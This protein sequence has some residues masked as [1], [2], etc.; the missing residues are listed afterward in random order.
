MGGGGLIHGGRLDEAM[1]RFGGRRENWLDLS[2]GINPWPWPV[3]ELAPEAW[4]RLPDA[5]AVSAAMEAARRCYG[6]PGE[7]HIVVGNGSQALIQALPLC[8]APASVA[9]VGPTYGEHERCWKLAGHRVATVPDLGAAA[10]ADVV[11]V[12]NPNNPDGRRTDP[13]ELLKYADRLGRRGG[14]LAVDEAFA[15]VTPEISVADAAGRPGLC[16]LRSFGKFF[17]L[18]GARVGFALCDA[19]IGSK[20][21][22]RLGPWST[23]GVALEVAARAL[24]DENWIAATRGRLA[25]EAKALRREVEG[26]DLEVAGSTD[27]YVLVECPDAD[28]LWRLLCEAHILTR[29]F[30]QRRRWLRLGLPA[31]AKASDR[32]SGALASTVSAGQ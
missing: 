26:C 21:E 30:A 24:S 32:L 4:A 5:A 6:A 16:V 31:N 3:P 22:A 17:G 27:L 10:G 13:A 7:A 9:V 19:G 20:L 15:D 25:R 14:L 28:A 11:V 8:V 29:Q 23:S 18:A 1:A 12:V 2:T